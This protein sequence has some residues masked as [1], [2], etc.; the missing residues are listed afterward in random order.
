MLDQQ[1]LT[2]AA[3]ALI[4]GAPLV[5]L[6][7]FLAIPRQ[8][9]SGTIFGWFLLSWGAQVINVNASFFV[10]TEVA[11]RSSFT[12]S[13]ALWA[14][15]WFLLAAFAATLNGGRMARVLAMAGSIPLLG[16]L[17]VLAVA[18]HRLVTTVSG[19]GW[20]TGQLENLANWLV[21]TPTILLSYAV[22]ALLYREYHRM[23][24]GQARHR[25]RGIV[26]GLSLYLSFYAGYQF[27]SWPPLRGTYTIG[28]LVFAAMAYHAAVR[29]AAPA[30]V[31]RGLVAAL[32]LPALFGF[33]EALWLRD[34][35][36]WHTLGW[37]RL[38]GAI[39]VAYT[40]A[41]Y[42]FFDLEL[43]ASRAAVP[44]LAAMTLLTGVVAA[45]ILAARGDAAL[46]A[47]PLGGGLALGSLAIMGRQKIAVMVVPGLREEQAYLFQRR[48]EVY[49]QNLEDAIRAKT[50]TNDGELRRLRRSLGLSDQ[51]HLLL[52]F[53]V[54]QSLG[55]SAAHRS[56]AFPHAEPG[57]ILLE[58]YRVERP[59]GEG[60]HGRAYLAH[61]EKLERD[62]VIKAVATAAVGG[63]AAKL[64]AREARIAGS[65]RHDNIIAVHDV[66]SGP[67]EAYLIMEFADAGNL[68]SLL[69]RRGRLSLAEATG[70]LDQILAGLG[71]AHAA[72]VVHR[73]IKP[74]NILLTRAGTVKLADFGVAR[75]SRPDATGL[76]G[77]ALG[78]LLY[79][80]PEQVRGRNVDARSDLYA[81][82]VVFH[83]AL[84]GRHY[85]PI[86]GQDDF[87]VRSMI[88]EQE[89]TLNVHQLPD[90]VEGMLRRSLAKDPS[91][92]FP[93]AQAMRQAI[94]SLSGGVVA[95]GDS[96]PWA[97]PDK[98]PTSRI[99]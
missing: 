62:V 85:L 86:A 96:L 23:P 26:L 55:R 43:K 16:C 84:T 14:L 34:L 69:R 64:L 8:G 73:D 38:A 49:R 5:V 79:M 98:Q 91:D 87:A 65:I 13:L 6:G 90:W 37:W 56:V 40:L 32:I 19:Q 72:G 93:D 7:L 36:L 4:P 24:F 52:E 78:T 99:G 61:D 47:I 11:A 51:D 74:E 41:R 50:G 59:L 31:D 60:A 82:A 57:A 15:T 18:P 3:L 70:L 97:M 68:H 95:S 28:I 66:E 17:G 27:V 29:P 54:R 58:R 35:G 67:D 30:G 92:R 46:A 2:E 53:L 1:W 39:M 9:R 88:L 20:V 42:Q 77:A 21:F 75:E 12:I 45:A 89:P 80:S 44:A 48:L 83:L 25:L 94:G 63:R 71:A 81:A 22:L 76:E 33:L 10:N